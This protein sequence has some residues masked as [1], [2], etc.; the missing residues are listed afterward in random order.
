MARV[1]DKIHTCENCKKEITGE[2]IKKGR[3]EYCEDCMFEIDP[4]WTDWC[5]LFEYI[6][7]LYNVE[8]VSVQI[9]T[10]LKKYNNESKMSYYGMLHT[11]RYVYEI[12]EKELDTD[13]GVGIIPY[14]YNKAEQFMNKKFDIEDKAE[15][16]NI[17]A[18]TQTITTKRQDNYKNQKKNINLDKWKEQ[19]E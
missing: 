15:E 6:K 10:Q 5:K 2:I 8:N 17:E 16:Y 18:T 13:K 14:F 11:L 7:R 9:I 3:K 4:D 19:T 1:K 12:L